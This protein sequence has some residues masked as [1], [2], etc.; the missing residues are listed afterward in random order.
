MRLV[1]DQEHSRNTSAQTKIFLS[2]TTRDRRDHD[3]AHKLA[4]GLRACGAQV[5][6]APDNIPTGADWEQE[7]VSG[8][9]QQ[10]SH[11]LAIVSAASAAS[12]WVQKE[13][14]LAQ[15][16]FAQEA[17][18]TILPLI[19]GRVDDFPGSNFINRFQEIPYHHEFSM[20]LNDLRESL[21]LLSA[22]LHLA[23]EPATSTHHPR[24]IGIRPDRKAFAIGDEIRILV[25][26]NCDCYLSLVNIGPA[27]TLTILLPSEFQTEAK[28]RA[29]QWHTFPPLEYGYKLP[30]MGPVGIE[31]LIGI[32]FADR[33]Q[34]TVEHFAEAGEQTNEPQ[35]L[36]RCLRETQK[37]PILGLA[38]IEFDVIEKELSRD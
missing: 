16:R 18:F 17:G 14:E 24:N 5:W 30:A 20:Q 32:A 6:I 38:V 23:V 26:A 12:E 19:V 34:L 36:L 9:M 1:K 27:G 8:V 3:L 29:G 35:E 7:I 11:F 25:L 4:E 37:L 10:C 2:H 15:Q 21:G 33:T 22:T 31:K 13:I 28:L